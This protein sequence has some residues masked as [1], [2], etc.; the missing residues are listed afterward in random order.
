M[1]R[2]SE[3]AT[4]LSGQLVGDA[5]LRVARPTEPLLAKAEDLAVALNS[6]FISQ[7]SESAAK[8]ALLPDGTDWS[9]LGLNA[10]ILVKRGRL[11]MAHMTQRLDTANRETGIHPTAIVAATAKLAQG[12]SV[13]PH[14]SIGENA[15]IGA[16]TSIGAGVRIGDNCNIG[17]DCILHPNV[18]IGADG[19][20]FVTEAPSHVEVARTT[21]GQGDVPVLDDP[22]WHRIHSLGGVLIG[23]EVEIGANSTVDAGTLRPTTI[24]NGTK[25]DNLVQIGHNAVIG[26]HCL[27][28]AQAGV[29]GSARVGDRSVLGG[30][31]G[32]ADNTTVGADVVIG[33]GSIVL[34]NVPD[35]R[36][37]LG[38]P[39][40]RMA[41]QLESY[42]ALRRLPRLL[43]RLSRTKT[44]FHDA[45]E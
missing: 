1:H 26:E 12:V 7:L 25:V 42:K 38:Y 16:G 32:L 4:S 35:G 13:G 20:S 11:A 36:V 9:S 33:G 3:I 43:A 21:L 37:M 27:I 19:F 41:G 39:A 17:A 45:D 34:S 44:G 23:D 2:I 15:Q 6:T 18:V 30:K 40:T 5:S 10:A 31:A 29:A 8:V 22:R 28:C 14:V 24:G